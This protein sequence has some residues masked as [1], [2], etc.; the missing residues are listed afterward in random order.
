MPEENKKIVKH[1]AE[2]RQQLTSM[3]LWKICA[4]ALWVFL[5]H[6][7]VLYS[8]AITWEMLLVRNLQISMHKLHSNWAI[9]KKFR[10]FFIQTTQKSANIKANSTICRRIGDYSM[11][12]KSNSRISIRLNA[13]IQKGVHNRLDLLSLYWNFRRSR[14]QEALIFYH[15]CQHHEEVQQ[16]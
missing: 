9:E 3:A 7:H 8:P 4:V 13:S 11:R 5:Q 1:G 2:E 14:R 16:G 15:V 6:E 10:D 12:T